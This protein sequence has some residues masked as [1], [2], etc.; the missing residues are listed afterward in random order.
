MIRIGSTVNRIG[1]EISRARNVWCC[2]LGG[3]CCVEGGGEPVVGGDPPWF[4]LCG[5]FGVAVF[6]AAPCGAGCGLNDVV[7]GGTPPPPVG[8]GGGELCC[9]GPVTGMTG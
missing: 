5:V 4:P 2:C 1:F 8:A 9:G 6:G 7:I 3:G